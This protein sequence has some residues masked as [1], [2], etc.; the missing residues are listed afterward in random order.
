[1]SCLYTYESSQITCPYP[2][3]EKPIEGIV[4]FPE[5]PIAESTCPHCGRAYM[6]KIATYTTTTLDLP[7]DKADPQI[8]A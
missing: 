4:V 2:G 6:V 1:M 7:N 8:I 3:C 5:R